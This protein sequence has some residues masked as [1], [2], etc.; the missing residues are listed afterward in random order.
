MYFNWF[1][2]VFYRVKTSKNLKNRAHTQNKYPTFAH[3]IFDL[4]HFRKV[5]SFFW[6]S[7]TT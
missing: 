3:E 7:Y 5:G 4:P 2:T 1:I 6:V